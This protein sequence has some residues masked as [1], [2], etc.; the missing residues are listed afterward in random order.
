[1]GLG[2]CV[3]VCVCWVCG[4]VRYGLVWCLCVYVGFEPLVDEAAAARTSSRY[5]VSGCLCV[6]RGGGA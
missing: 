2:V 1:M 3:C 4:K 6:C 5:G